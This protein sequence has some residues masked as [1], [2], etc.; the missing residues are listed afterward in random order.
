MEILTQWEYKTIFI[1]PNTDIAGE[2]NKAGLDGWECFDINHTAVG[3]QCCLKRPKAVRSPLA[4][5]RQVG[6][7]PLAPDGW[8]RTTGV[9]KTPVIT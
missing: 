8:D 9:D 1:Q 3:I 6:D 7:K 5:V 4:P 2:L